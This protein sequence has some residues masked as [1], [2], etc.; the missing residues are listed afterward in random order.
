MKQFAAL[1]L[2]AVFAFAC[3]SEK[4]YVKSDLE[5]ANLKGN[6]WKVDKTIHDA[7]GKCACPA[8]TKTECNQSKYVYDKKGNIIESCT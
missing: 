2:I 1:L 6:V 4:S 3:K 7:N 5:A 8:A